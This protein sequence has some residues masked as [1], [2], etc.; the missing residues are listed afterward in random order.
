M[1]VE[2]FLML[3][4]L[5]KKFLNNKTYFMWK[6]SFKFYQFTFGRTFLIELFALKSYQMLK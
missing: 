2:N 4:Y 6:F 1:K 5:I 3:Y